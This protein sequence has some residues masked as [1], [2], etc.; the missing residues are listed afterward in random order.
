MV[1]KRQREQRKNAG[2]A[3][4]EYFKKRRQEIDN[5]ARHHH[6]VN[7][8][9]PSET[10]TEDEARR[11]WNESANESQSDSEE[12]GDCGLEEDEETEKKSARD[13]QAGQREAEKKERVEQPR[14]NKAAATLGLGWKAGGDNHLKGTYGNGSRATQYRKKDGAKELGKEA[15][16]SYQIGT[17]WQRN[18]DL[19]MISA[20]RTES[21]PS[22][23]LDPVD[24]LP[25][26]YS[27]SQIP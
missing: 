3:S 17:L 8:D 6:D 7:N 15:S 11:F 9:K 23:P 2:A 18:R 13:T 4:V 22:A 26:P 21:A 25:S 12:E 1:S 14:T 10:D 27:L 24:S 20:P 5:Q 16:Q 19:G